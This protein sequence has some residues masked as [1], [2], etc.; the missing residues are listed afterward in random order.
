MINA[1]VMS[2]ICAQQKSPMR[3]SQTVGY[4]GCSPY[5]LVHMSWASGLNTIMSIACEQGTLAVSEL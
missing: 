5:M 3:S 1:N 4:V 2:A